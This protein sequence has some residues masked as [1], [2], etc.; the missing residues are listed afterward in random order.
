MSEPPSQSRI[1]SLMERA[2]TALVETEYFAAADDASR[3]FDLARRSNDFERMARICLPIQEA[4]RQ[5]RQAAADAGGCTIIS[6]TDEI[7]SSPDAGCYLVQPPLIGNDAA[8]LRATLD[9]RRIP[10]ML[11]CREPMTRAGLWPVVAVG[12]LI[13]RTRVEPPPGV[14]RDPDRATKDSIDG[15]IPVTWFDRASEALGDAAIASVDRSEPAVYQLEDL[16]SYLP[17]IPDHEKLLQRIAEVC[18]LAMH[19][20]VPSGPRRRRGVDDPFSF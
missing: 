6:T 15:P 4:R 13:A 14:V 2:S 19:E 20:P 18:R 17:A 10:V 9:R 7:P 8:L 3:A 1:D 16:T 12:R 11:V 5:I